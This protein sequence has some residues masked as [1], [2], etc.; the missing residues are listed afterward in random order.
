MNVT[1]FYAQAVERVLFTGS[2]DSH[3]A[4]SLCPVP[5]SV[6]REHSCDKRHFN[7]AK[8]AWAFINSHGEWFF[9]SRRFMTW[10]NTFE[11]INE[12]PDGSPTTG[13]SSPLFQESVVLFS[14]AKKVPE[15]RRNYAQVYSYATKG[16]KRNDTTVV[17]ESFE[18]PEGKATTIE[19]WGRFLDSLNGEEVSQAS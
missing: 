12:L 10:I 2:F 19:A 4:N 13:S 14:D 6:I 16:I 11:D 8:K 3:Q 5:G 18:M 17:L 15:I 9:A 1:F 7:K